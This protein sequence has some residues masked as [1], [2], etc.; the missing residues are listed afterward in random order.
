M[1]KYLLVTALIALVVGAVVA[2]VSVTRATAM[3]THHRDAA[4]AGV[5]GGGCQRL[6]KDPKAMQ[7]MHDLHPEHLKDI[8]AWRDR[9]GSDPSSTEAKQALTR[10][11]REHRAET[12]AALREAGVK[13]PAGLC[14]RKMMRDAVI[15]T[16]A[17]MMGSDGAGMMGDSSGSLHEQHHSG[18]S[19]QASGMM[20][21]ADGAFMMGGS[22]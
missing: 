2:G 13:A 5:P 12:K 14:T 8:Q 3:T 10:L 7:V 6:M 9:Y 18:T 17:G 19:G 22:Y 20:G 11:W 16:G 15:G 4:A 21:G 1:R